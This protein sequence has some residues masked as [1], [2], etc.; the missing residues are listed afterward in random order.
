MAASEPSPVELCRLFVLGTEERGRL[1]VIEMAEELVSPRSCELR[2]FS[3]PEVDEEWRISFMYAPI[4]ADS[5]SG[6]SASG[7]YQV[8]NK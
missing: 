8:L 5:M 2:L 4:P 7:T 6:W 1:L 3:R